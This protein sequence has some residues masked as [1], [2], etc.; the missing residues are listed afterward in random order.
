MKGRVQTLYQNCASGKQHKARRHQEGKAKDQRRER[1]SFTWAIYTTEQAKNLEER[2]HVLSDLNRTRAQRGPDDELTEEEF[3][4]AL[5]RSGKD[6]EPGPDKIR[7]SDTN[8][9]TEEDLSL[10]HI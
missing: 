3:N 1:S 8:K 2:K 5:R 7:Y 10:I 4:E 6:I 9:L